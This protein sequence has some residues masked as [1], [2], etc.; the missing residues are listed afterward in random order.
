MFSV[1]VREQLTELG[2]RLRRLRLDRNESQE[3]FAT[4][5]GVSIPTLRK[6]ERGDPTV[7]VGLW[8]DA[9][10][11]LDR[12]SDLERLLVPQQSLFD[13]FE[14]QQKKLRQRASKRK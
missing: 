1:K 13:Q 6:M 4:R 7:S 12:L 10:W 8:A 5:L 14:K 3:R 2:Q 11:L 9:L